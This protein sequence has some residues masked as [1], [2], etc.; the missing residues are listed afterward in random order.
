MANEKA[1]ALVAEM[2]SAY[3][4]LDVPEE[5]R[6]SLARHN[7]HLVELTQELIGSGLDEESIKSVI[8]SSMQSYEA[9]LIETILAVRG[10]SSD[11]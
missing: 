4:D 2:A 11:G 6:E 3:A 10:G 7:R 5:L 1:E 9:E 8:N